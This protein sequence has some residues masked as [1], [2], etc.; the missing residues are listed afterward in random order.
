RREKRKFG[1]SSA[2]LCLPVLST[3]RHLRLPAE[4]NTHREFRLG[5]VGTQAGLC[6][7]NYNQIETLPKTAVF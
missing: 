5:I 7:R 3:G 2:F 4:V 1:V 6:V